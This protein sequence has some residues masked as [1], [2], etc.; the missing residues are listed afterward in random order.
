[1][2]PGPDSKKTTRYT[3][4]KFDRRHR[5]Y[6]WWRSKRDGIYPTHIVRSI[7]HQELEREL[8]GERGDELAQFI[9]EYQDLHFDRNRYEDDDPQPPLRGSK[10][11]DNTETPA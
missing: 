2:R 4:I 7:V 1:M 10:A 5:A 11:K 6:L 9:R 8:R 3:S